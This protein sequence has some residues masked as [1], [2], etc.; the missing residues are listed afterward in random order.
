MSRRTKKKAPAVD[1][2]ASPVVVETFMDIGAYELSRMRQD[3]PSAFNGSVRVHRYRITVERVDEPREVIAERIRKLWRECDNW[4]HLTP[5]RKAAEEIDLD[6]DSA[7]S[8]RAARST[9]VTR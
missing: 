5:L 8:G 4:H 2:W 1:P 3:E 9:E 6:L 7:E